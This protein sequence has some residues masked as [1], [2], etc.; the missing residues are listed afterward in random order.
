LVNQCTLPPP[1]F[2][3]SSPN[4]WLNVSCPMK[5]LFAHLWVKQIAA[6]VVKLQ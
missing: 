5:T 3:S 2:I 4:I 1:L 6:A